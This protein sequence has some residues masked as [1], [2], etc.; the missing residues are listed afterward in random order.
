MTRRSDLESLGYNIITWLGG[1]LP[2]EDCLGSP[3]Q[4]AERKEQAMSNIRYFLKESFPN[5]PSPS[6]KTFFNF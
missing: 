3:E 1:R 6:G 2:W 4:V 5:R